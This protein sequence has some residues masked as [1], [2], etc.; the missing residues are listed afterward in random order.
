LVK[1]S[2]I[3]VDHIV[4]GLLPYELYQPDNQTFVLDY[5]NEVKPYHVQN[6]AFN[7]IYD[8]IDI[9]PGALTDYD[10]P[11]YWNTT[12]DLPQFVSPVLTPYTYSNSVNQ[13]F[14]SDAAGNAQIWLERPWSDWFNNYT[15][16]LNS[17]DVNDT[18][19]SYN[20]VPVITVGAEWEAD[21]AYT[22]GQQ[23]AYRSNLYTVTV[24]GTTS[25]TAPTFT[26]GNAV[27]GTA[28]LAYT[29]T[30]AQATAT[31]RT[32]GTIAA[33]TVIVAGSGYLT[34]PLIAV[35]GVYPNFTTFVI[36]LV[37]VLLEVIIVFSGIVTAYE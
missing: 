23:I 12:L 26:F 3:E 11:A 2:Y 37:P 9:Y 5:L 22:V 1:T 34:T 21:T 8:G 13:S 6:L 28:T 36:K 29:G 27:D 31:L 10:V 19:T 30:R 16:S 18:T 7:L 35:N 24:A 14:I 25:N 33:V 17:V 4:R 32:N 20:D 15:L